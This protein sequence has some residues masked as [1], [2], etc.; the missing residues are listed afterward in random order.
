MLSMFL[1]TMSVGEN[2]ACGRM[3]RILHSHG[4]TGNFYMSRIVA[5]SVPRPVNKDKIHSCRE[6]L[7]AL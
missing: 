4:T 6:V 2:T 3:Q 5:K 1:N 7:R